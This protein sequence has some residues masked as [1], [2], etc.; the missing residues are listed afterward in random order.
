[1]T[2]ESFSP[3][4]SPLSFVSLIYNDNGA[5]LYT[6]R[7]PFFP[8]LTTLRKVEEECCIFTHFAVVDKVYFRNESVKVAFQKTNKEYLIN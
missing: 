8:Q 1:M 6:A 4:L 5:V 7:W 3:P 2:A